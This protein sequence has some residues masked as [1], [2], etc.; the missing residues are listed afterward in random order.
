MD[1]LQEKQLQ[2]K[3]GFKYRYFVSS[4]YNPSNPVLLL[5]HGWPDNASLW[6]YVL[7]YLLPL[8]CKIVV[9]DLLGYAG[10]D[11]PTDLEAYD[12]RLMCQDM[13]DLLAAE[14]IESN[15][16]AVG[17]DFGIAYM[18]PMPQALDPDVFFHLGQQEDGSSRYIYWEL[19]TSPEAPKLFAQHNEAVWHALHGAPEDMV[20]QMF[21]FKDAFKNFLLQD[22]TDVGLRPYAQNKDLHDAWIRDF[23]TMLQWEVS[24]A[25]YN[26]FISGVQTAVD[27]TIA[28][29][30]YRLEMPVLFIS[31]DGDAV[32]PHTTIDGPK[33]AG[34]LSDLTER[35]L[36]CGHWCPYEKPE[37]LSMMIVDWVKARRAAKSPVNITMSSFLDLPPELRNYIYE[38]IIRN[39][40]R[41]CLT[42]A[43]E[44]KMRHNAALRRLRPG[45]RRPAMACHSAY[46]RKL[47][48]ICPMAYVCL[49]T[50][51]EVTPMIAV[52]RPLVPITMNF[53]F[54][55]NE[56]TEEA[57]NSSLELRV[58]KDDGKS[59][60]S[61]VKY[62]IHP[63]RHDVFMVFEQWRLHEIVERKLTAAIRA[64]LVEKGT[65]LL[66]GEFD[67]DRMAALTNRELQ[68]AYTS[69]WPSSVHW[70]ISEHTKHVDSLHK[71]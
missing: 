19:F 68:N 25:W 10:T 47:H 48:I 41:F 33:G 50:R 64:Y 45:K 43:D 38:L 44:A 4:H 9:P 65:G 22:R 30:K 6:Q 18:P 60:V 63:G 70:E 24:F 67:L 46:A 31:C 49:Q 34:L 59:V 39:E 14:D 32:N 11:K 56:W 58:F 28:P 36:H 26:S 55:S 8:N 62:G 42:V 21:C 66:V 54:W 12:Y 16:I 5:L 57:V 53:G 13:L 27:K 52:L 40:S 69:S 7:P 61:K 29:E 17:H 3:R 37:Q 1:G 15:V 20:K 51:K 23:S 2:V 71:G 35:E